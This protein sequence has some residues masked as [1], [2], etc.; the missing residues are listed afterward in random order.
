M[1]AEEILNI[2]DFNKDYSHIALYV[3]AFTA[4]V[5]YVSIILWLVFDIFARISKLRVK[6][7]LLSVVF[8]IVLAGFVGFI[9][10]HPLFALAFLVIFPYLFIY[11]LFR[12]K[13]KLNDQSSLLYSREEIILFEPELMYCQ[14]CQSLNRKSYLHCTKC[15]A[16]L[17]KRCNKCNILVDP[18]WAY[19]PN[20]SNDLS[21][22]KLTFLQTK[23]KKIKGTFKNLHTKIILALNYKTESPDEQST[24]EVNEEKILNKK[25]DAPKTKGSNLP[26]HNIKAKK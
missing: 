23:I 19:C 1:Q 11:L 9:F 5:I 26:I 2:I 8:I 7:F 18:I 6:V 15:G 10:I 21:E 24:V 3:I 13:L 4:L 16:S 22:K 20:C 12:P 17:E 25:E 14:E